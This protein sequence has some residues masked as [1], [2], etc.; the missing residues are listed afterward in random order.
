MIKEVV[1]PP[2]IRKKIRKFPQN[3]RKKFC[4]AIEML[5][6]NERYPSLRHKKIAGA[7]DFWEFSITMNYRGLYKRNGSKALLVRVGKHEDVF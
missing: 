3:I 2:F 1:I 5:M 4:D 7:E 6:K